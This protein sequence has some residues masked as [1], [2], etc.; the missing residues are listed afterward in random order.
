VAL[1]GCP[2]A[3]D[4]T[5]TT[6]LP[7]STTDQPVDDPPTDD[8]TTDSTTDQTTDPHTAVGTSH[9]SSH[10]TVRAGAEV[11]NVIVTL[12][13]SGDSDT[14]ELEA[15]T[16]RGLTQEMHDRGHDVRVVVER[17]EET[18]FDQTVRGYQAFDLVVY[19]NDTDVTQ[20]AV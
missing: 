3:P 17:G 4:G 7:T 1:A 8:A 6:E 9:A 16:Q 11:Q 2:S 10:F 18:V 20:V 5:G 13:P 12:A 14:V 15:G 19:E